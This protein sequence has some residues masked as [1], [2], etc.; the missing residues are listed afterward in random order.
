MP[1]VEV[2]VIVTVTDDSGPTTK[3]FQGQGAADAMAALKNA[4]TAME[5][6]FQDDQAWTED[7]KYRYKEQLKVHQNEVTQRQME[8]IN[9]GRQGQSA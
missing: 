3:S 6:I 2:L 4:D 1:N 8:I 7:R 9:E 5:L